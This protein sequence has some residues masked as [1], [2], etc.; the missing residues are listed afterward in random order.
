MNKFFKGFVR[1]SMLVSDFVYQYEKALNSRYLKEKEKDVKT[2]NSNPIMKTCYGIEVEVAKIYTRKMFL[3]FQDGLFL[4]QNYKGSKSGIDETRKIY[5]VVHIGMENPAYVVNLDISQNK[6][7]CT[8]H[9]FEFC[10]ILCRHIL[11]IFVTKS[12]VA[13]FPKQYILDGWTIQAKTHD[14][15]DVPGVNLEEEPFTYMRKNLII[16]FLEV[17]ELGYGSREKYNYLNW[18]VKRFV[19]IS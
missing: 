13:S 2:K 3:K 16:E 6:A 9:M 18:A 12:M 8:C 19:E 15:W 5:N 11:A 4:S 14:I 17:L 10:G 7:T 1:S